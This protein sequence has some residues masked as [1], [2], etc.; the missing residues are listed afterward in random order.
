MRVDKTGNGDQAF[1]VDLAL[2]LV[3][4]I[5]ADDAVA[6]DGDIAGDQFAGHQVQKFSVLDDDIGIFTSQGL[7]DAMFQKFRC[8]G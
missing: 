6:A 3:C 5:G 2:A 4:F 8:D 1:A 7:V